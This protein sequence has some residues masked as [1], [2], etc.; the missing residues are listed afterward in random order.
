MRRPIALIVFALVAFTG[1]TG[2]ASAAGLSVTPNTWDSIGLRGNTSGLPESPNMFPVGAEVCNTSGSDLNDVSATFVWDSA[3]PYI[4][5]NNGATIPVGPLPAGDCTDVY[6]TVSIAKDANA[7]FTSRAYHI[8][9]TAT[10]ASGQTPAGRQLFVEKLVEQNRNTTEAISGPGGCNGDFTVCDPP[11]TNLVL[12]GTYT[13]KLYANTAT[14]YEQLEAF[15]TFPGSIFRVKEVLSEY[16]IPAGGMVDG[17]YA[18]ACGW[19]PDPASGTYMS[20]TGPIPPEFVSSAGK[21][22]GDV[23]VTY[24]VA[25][26]SAPAPAA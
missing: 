12:G 16:E 3:N 14:A 21:V 15:L 18:D 8:E 17:A 25:K 11:P 24:E 9:L 6:Y 22:G 7:W 4:G 10:G 2:M 26:S 20:C 13:Y 19:D 1:M 23:I 5:L